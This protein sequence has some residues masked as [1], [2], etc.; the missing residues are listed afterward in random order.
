LPKGWTIP[1]IVECGPQGFSRRAD[2][3]V[4]INPLHP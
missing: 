1:V 3:R 4:G 2:A